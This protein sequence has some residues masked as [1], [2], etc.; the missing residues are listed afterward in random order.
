MIVIDGLFFLDILVNFNCAY[1]DEAHKIRDNR[2]EI[3]CNY[4]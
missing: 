4:L 1:E 2:K 3:A